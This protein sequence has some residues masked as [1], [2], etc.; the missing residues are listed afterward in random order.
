[1]I[2]TDPKSVEAAENLV[3]HHKGKRSGKQRSP[4]E[5]SAR[6]QQAIGQYQ[7]LM[8][9]EKDNREQRVMLYAEIKALGWCQGRDEQQIIQ[10]INR[11][12]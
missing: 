8:R 5:I 10:D 3:R 9:S 4:Q 1:M 11:L 7:S 12:R 6:Y 2:V